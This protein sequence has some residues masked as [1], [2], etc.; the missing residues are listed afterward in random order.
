M[1]TSV[2]RRSDQN[3]RVRE[4]AS[5]G[6]RHTLTPARAGILAAAALALLAALGIAATRQVRGRFG[7]PTTRRGTAALPAVPDALDVSVPGAGNARLRGWFLT[8]Q[9][10]HEQGPA[11]LVM[12]GWGGSALDMAPLAAPLRE[13]G[14]HTLLLDAR[15]HGR[16]DDS[17]ITSMPH[18]A[19]DVA[20]G[21]SWLRAHP[22]VDPSRIVLVGHSVG[23]GA[24]LLAAHRDPGV[25]GVVS[26]SCM[27]DPRAVMTRLLSGA[28]LPRAVRWLALRYVE[29]DIGM[30]FAAFTPLTTLPTLTMPV[31]LIHGELDQVVPAA[32]AHQ[33]AAVAPAARLLVVPGVGHADIDGV[34]AVSDIVREFVARATQPQPAEAPQ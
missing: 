11:A 19:D 29:H 31:L 17:A 18:F 15:S 8:G 26:L 33:L 13:A 2:P 6:D 4:S 7:R 5:I 28:H 14:V 32:D 1:G 22:L 25:A 30:R 9:A 20:A 16:S 3:Q 34:A 21:L 24:C 27:A 23:A 10:S 12:H